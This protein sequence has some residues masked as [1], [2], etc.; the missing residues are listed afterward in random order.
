[1]IKMTETYCEYMP[2]LINTGYGRQQRMDD[3]RNNKRAM[4]DSP[5]LAKHLYDRVAPFQINPN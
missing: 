5:K 2:A 3:I 4:I 1:M